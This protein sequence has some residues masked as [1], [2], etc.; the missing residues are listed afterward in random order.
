MAFAEQQRLARKVAWWSVGISGILGV[1]KISIG[2]AAHSVAVVSD[3][4]ESAAD[5]FTSGL[6]LVGLWVAAK[7]PDEDHPYGHGRFETLVGLAIGVILV[8][9]GTTI[10]IRALEQHDAAV[11]PA[12]YAIWPLAAS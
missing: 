3:G 8:A 10:S 4:F 12:L 7:P 2:L 9:T 6:V 5:C 11:T 1:L